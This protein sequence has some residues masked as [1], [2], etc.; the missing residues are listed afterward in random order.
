MYFDIEDFKCKLSEQGINVTQLEISRVSGI[1]RYTLSMAEN[2]NDGVY[3]MRP[4]AVYRLYKAYPDGV[5]LPEDFAW[6]S[7]ASFRLSLR[8]Y[9]GTKTS[10]SRKI[11]MSLTALDRKISPKSKF[12]I[13][14]AKSVFSDFDSI[15][16]PYIQGHPADCYPEKPQLGGLKDSIKRIIRENKRFGR[17]SKEKYGANIIMNQLEKKDLSEL[18]K[19]MVRDGKVLSV[20]QK[21][22]ILCRAL[23]DKY[24][25][26]VYELQK[27]EA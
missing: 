8:F 1:N 14:D 4:D 20:E 3:N 17:V 21:D 13:Y 11:G 25:A 16:V 22:W 10:L 27:E 26:V 6:Y 19:C 24:D 7:A 2:D 18:D 9:D 12:F 23:G 5:E 15:Y